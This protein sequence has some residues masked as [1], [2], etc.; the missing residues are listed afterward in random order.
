MD[1]EKLSKEELIA[2]VQ[3]LLKETKESK[4]EAETTFVDVTITS[5]L[6]VFIMTN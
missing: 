3:S 5:P 2:L 6:K 4:G 1:L